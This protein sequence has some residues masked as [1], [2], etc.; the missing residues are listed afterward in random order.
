MI[1]MERNQESIIDRMPLGLAK[2][3]PLFKKLTT[4]III[5]ALIF[6]VS[7][8]WIVVAMGAESPITSN[9][10]DHF[11][12]DIE[13]TTESD[14]SSNPVC[15]KCHDTNLQPS[16]DFP[17]ITEIYSIS[18]LNNILA[19]NNNYTA[20][21]Q[22]G[23]TPY[24]LGPFFRGGG[25][26]W[27]W[28]DVDDWGEEK[29][30][31]QISLM[32]FDNSTGTI[33]PVTGL[34]TT[35][36]WPYASYRNHSGNFSYKADT[37]P[38]PITTQNNYPDQIDLW[39]IKEV[40]LSDVTTANLT[41]WTWYS[42]ETDYDYGFVVISTNGG[43]TWTY[44]PGSLTTSTNPNGNNLGNGITGSSNNFWSLENMDLSPYTGNRILL[45]FRFKSD[46]GSNDEGWYIDDIQVKSGTTILFSDDAET[47][48]TMKTL[49]V[50]V[51]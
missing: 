4:F 37:D 14:I 17:L 10:N 46:G 6:I 41:F 38:S 8:N 43:N 29:Q 15:M 3:R 16:T 28:W 27:S 30:K 48:A 13:N 45:G 39:M 18:L 40:D 5:T 7:G 25:T 11:G 1:E 12:I 21:L 35:P 42:M 36:I 19:V 51:T 24:Q 9:G 50:N 47:L 34:T 32:V 49:S 31:N 33:K 26:G 44:L 22:V 20:I 2:Q 23:Q